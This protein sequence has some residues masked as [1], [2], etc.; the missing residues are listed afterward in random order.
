MIGKEAILSV[1][2][3]FILTLYRHVLVTPHQESLEFVLV[4]INCSI[5]DIVSEL[6]KSSTFRHTTYGHASPGVA[7]FTLRDI[8][9]EGVILKLAIL[10]IRIDRFE[11]LVCAYF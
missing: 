9:L 10:C 3:D 8:C 5:D 7:T 1:F 6:I 4:L 2:S 11:N